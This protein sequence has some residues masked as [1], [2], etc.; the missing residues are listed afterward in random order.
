MV[1]MMVLMQVAVV[2]TVVAAAAAV[3]V[4]VVVVVVMVML[5]MLMKPLA[6]AVPAAVHC[7]ETFFKPKKAEK[8]AG[9]L[10]H[11][12]LGGI[13][14]SGSAGTGSSTGTSTTTHVT[15]A[16][17]QAVFPP[18]LARL[19]LLATPAGAR[20]V[21]KTRRARS[22]CVM[23]SFQTDKLDMAVYTFFVIRV[24]YSESSKNLKKIYSKHF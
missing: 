9:I 22:F 1:V 5:L 17:I 10:L 11:R 2:A 14:T 3:V 13:I 15:V 18:T 23:S 6:L 20:K 19:K 7:P 12:R 21:T 4:V 16:P 8:S 24:I